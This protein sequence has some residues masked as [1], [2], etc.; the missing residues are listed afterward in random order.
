[1]ET[2]DGKDRKSLPTQ[3]NKIWR[4]RKKIPL[5]EADGAL[6]SMLYTMRLEVEKVNWKNS[7]NFY[8]IVVFSCMTMI[9]KVMFISIAIYYP[10]PKSFN[11]DIKSS[12]WRLYI[13]EK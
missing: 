5:R 2:I 9:Y 11:G 8:I 7:R 4:R 10:K 13:L 6:G 1:M 3:K 12:A